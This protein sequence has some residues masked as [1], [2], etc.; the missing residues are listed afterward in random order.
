MAASLIGWIWR[1]E[2]SATAKLVLFALNEHT[3]ISEH[4][5]WRVFPSQNRIANM[6]G[7]SKRSVVRSMQEL[8]EAGVIVVAHQ[9]NSTGRQLQNLYWLQAPKLI[10]EEGCQNVTHQCQNVTPEGDKL[11][12]KSLY[13]NPSNKTNTRKKNKTPMPEGFGI[14]DG[15]RKWAER[16]GH[17]RLNAHLENFI[18]AADTYGLT[19]VNWDSAF[20]IAIRKNWAKIQ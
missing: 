2:V 7:L 12:H 13:K 11:A 4:G 20:K 3:N 19:Y 9:H 17:R 10:E 14:S 18:D 8:T 5:D 15:V 1:Q 16:N 6:C